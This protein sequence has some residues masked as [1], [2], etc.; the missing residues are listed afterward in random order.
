M[1]KTLK[2]IYNQ[3]ASF[4][5]FPAALPITRGHSVFR[6]I[7]ANYSEKVLTG[8][9]LRLSLRLSRCFQSLLCE[10]SELK[11][12]GIGVDCITLETENNVRAKMYTLLNHLWGHFSDGLHF[13]CFLITCLN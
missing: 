9:R 6:R 8:S 2:G 12:L 1:K 3:E 4:T 5:H 7:D 13:V 10:D 11:D